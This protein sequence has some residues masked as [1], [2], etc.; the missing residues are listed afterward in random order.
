MS[1]IAI[2]L[3]ITAAIV[4]ADFEVSKSKCF[5]EGM[6]QGLPGGTYTTDLA[7]LDNLPR[8]YRL[9][10]LVYCRRLE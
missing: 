9:T 6:S 5:E 2:L 10:K 1:R 4:S 8:N 7:T 3:L